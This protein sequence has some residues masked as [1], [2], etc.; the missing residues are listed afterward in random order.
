MKTFVPVADTKTTGY[1]YNPTGS[2]GVLV[3]SNAGQTPCRIPL[4]TAVYA[5]KALIGH[6]GRIPEFK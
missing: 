6:L 5:T 3:V 1:R 2:G 4:K